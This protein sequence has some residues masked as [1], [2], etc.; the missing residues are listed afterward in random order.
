MLLFRSSKDLTSAQRLASAQLLVDEW[1][2]RLDARQEH[3]ENS[4]C[5]VLLVGG[6]EDVIVGHAELKRGETIT[7]LDTIGATAHQQQHQGGIGIVTSVVIAPKYRGKGHGLRLMLQVE[8]VAA[9]Q[10]NYSYLYL[11]TSDAVD[12]YKKLGYRSSD[13]A[14][15]DSPALR[16]LSE[17][18]RQGLQEVLLRRLSLDSSSPSPTTSTLPTVWLRKRLIATLPLFTVQISS[19]CDEIT[20]KSLVVT[21]ALAEAQAATEGS[22]QFIGDCYIVGQE[23]EE[24]LLFWCAQLGPSCGIAALTMAAAHYLHHPSSSPCAPAT[25]LSKFFFDRALALGFSSDGEIFDM[26]HLHAIASSWTGGDCADT[27]TATTTATCRVENTAEVFADEQALKYLF[28]T[29]HL[30]VLPYD[31]DSATNMPITKDGT[32]AHYAL[33]IGYYYHTIDEELHLVAMHGMSRRPVCAPLSAWL[34][35]NQ[36]LTTT[37]A[38][39]GNAQAWVVDGLTGPKLADKVLHFVC[40]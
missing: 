13:T 30:F 4:T 6:E 14:S 24:P 2:G 29:G 1:G 21:E 40:S 19:L 3:I 35:S 32:C 20:Q 12:F 23:R 17:S 27:S 16:S 31:R 28:Q 8:K 5:F 37:R 38:L 39:K 25:N 36:Q 22:R 15:I 34:V 9:E 18:S 26:D 10:F 11:W 7:S 33:L